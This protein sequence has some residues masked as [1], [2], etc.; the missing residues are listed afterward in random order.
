MSEKTGRENRSEATK[1][2]AADVA[3]VAQKQAAQ[4][5]TKPRKLTAWQRIG[6]RLLGIR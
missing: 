3:P 5:G 2:A 6:A 1:T 4:R